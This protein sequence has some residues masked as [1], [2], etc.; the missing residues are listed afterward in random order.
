MI[1][2]HVEPAGAM[3]RAIPL[4]GIVPQNQGPIGLADFRVFLSWISSLT[5][6]KMA[7]NAPF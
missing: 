5:L 1:F 7:K 4:H 3:S 2:G 6:R